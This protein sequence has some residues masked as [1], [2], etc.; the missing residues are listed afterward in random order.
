MFTVEI[1]NVEFT[2]TQTHKYLLKLNL[3]FIRDVLFVI[4]FIRFLE[5]STNIN[6]H[7]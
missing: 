2:P 4:N 5:E 6:T 1:F 3:S 7:K